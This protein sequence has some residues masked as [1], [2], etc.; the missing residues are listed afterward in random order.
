LH[1]YTVEFSSVN[2]QGAGTLR[3]GDD[4]ITTFP[5]KNIKDARSQARAFALEHREE[6]RPARVERYTEHFSL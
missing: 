6:S 3:I 1:Q 5:A 2:G 4:V